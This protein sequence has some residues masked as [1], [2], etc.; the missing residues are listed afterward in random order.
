MKIDDLIKDLEEAR[1]VY[2]NLDIYAEMNFDE[3]CSECGEPKSHIYDG[4]S[5]Y[6]E[7]AN[8]DGKPTFAIITTRDSERVPH[9]PQE[10]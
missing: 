8:I 6:G 3:D 7:A 10:A 9:S 1:K 2:G 5:A 4:F